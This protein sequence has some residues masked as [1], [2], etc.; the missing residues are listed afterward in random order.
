M[1]KIELPARMEHLKTILD[2]I[3]NEADAAEFPKARVSKI[4]LAAEEVLV[5][6]FSYAYP[7]KQGHVTIS[8][9]R[10]NDRFLLKVLDRG[11][12]FNMLEASDPDI[13]SG[14]SE[15]C[16]GGLGIYFVKQ[17]ADEARY[18][19]KEGE[20]RLTLV[21]KKERQKLS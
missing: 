7:E 4:R 9:F 18:V 6:I 2:F 16:L 3:D 11:V 5:N 10:K 14:L 21:F 8:C 20:N 12:P 13:S 1:A 15:R 17:M 19:R